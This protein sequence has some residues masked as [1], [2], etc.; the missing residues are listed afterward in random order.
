MEAFRLAAVF[1]DNCVLQ[2]GKNI[3]IFGNGREGM[4]VEAVLSGRVLGSEK[5]QESRGSARVRNGRFEI[6][7]PALEAGLDHTLTVSAGAEKLVRTNIAIGE[8]WLAGGQS[9]MEFE[10]Q[11]CTEHAVLENPAN[12][13]IR[14][15]YTQKKAYM[16]E[17]FFASEAQTAWECFGAE[18]TKYWS[19]VGYFFAAKLQ[20][21]LK[22]PVGIIGCNWGGT[23]ASAWMSKEA[24]AADKELQIYLDTYEE[25]VQGKSEEEQRREYDEYVIYQAEFDRKA[26]ACYREN[27]DMEWAEVLEIV[28]E[29]RWPGPMGC[30][31]PYRPAGL[32][33]CM[34][35]R[36]MPYSLKGFLYYQGESDDHLPHLYYRLFTRMIG[37]WREDWQDDTLPFVF[38]QLPMHR[39]KQD[40]DFKNWCLIRE[41]QQRVYDTVR[42]TGMACILDQ[43][44]YNDIHPKAKKVVGERMCAQALEIAYGCDNSAKADGPLFDYAEILR[45]GIRLHFKYAAAGFLLKD[46]DMK[47]WEKDRRVSGIGF[48]IAGED[49][50]YMP[51][52]AVAEQNA[53]TGEW[54]LLLDSDTVDTPVFAR[55]QW[56]NY[57]EVLLFGQNGIP[58]APFRTSRRDGFVPASQK[59]EIQQNMECANK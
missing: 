29:C 26:D 53:G 41:A 27:P 57:G 45:H 47:A 1:S 3:A 38:A 37:Q 6:F 33:E 31:N 7:L 42:Y 55:Y 5:Q 30:S 18:G 50:S 49:G 52:S 16:D 8:V 51:A 20:E 28:G 23:S 25:A 24:I 43:G 32:Y 10:L 40:P 15:Y 2:R 17:E 58:L 44:V 35:K 46:A 12:E 11:N 4:L 39:Y 54:T 59:A 34:L 36:V 48:E 14:F 22:V 21:E 56:T 9:N 13:M 19:A